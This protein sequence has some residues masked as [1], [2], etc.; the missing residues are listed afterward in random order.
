M[1]IFGRND[2]GLS[3]ERWGPVGENCIYLHRDVG[4]DKCF[5]HKCLKGFACLAA[6]TPEDVIK[7]SE[8][9]LDQSD[10]GV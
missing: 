4:C 3:P 2:P 5:A 1:A 7:A 8:K 10:F 9:I 6:I